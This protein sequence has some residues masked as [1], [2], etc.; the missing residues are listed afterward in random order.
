[1]PLLSWPDRRRTTENDGQ[2]M[3]ILVVEDDEKIAETLRKGLE[4]EGYR[5]R[6]AADGEEGFYRACTEPCDLIL[7]DLMLP[8]RDGLEVLRAVRRSGCRVPVLILTARDGVADRVAGLDDGADDYLVKPFSFAELLA[9]IRALLRRGSGTPAT[10][11]RLADLEVDRLRREARRGGSLLHLTGREFGLL[12]YL[13]RHAGQVV[14]REMLARDVWR[15][16]GRATPL[17][18]IIDVYIS[19][20]RKKVD[21][22]HPVRLIHTI[23]GVGFMAREE[24]G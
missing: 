1:M 23:R 6:L 13:L 5:V 20:L 2:A 15:E 21:Q 10:T 11:V 12:E 8:G 4:G 24:E 16:A 22:D 3:T 19:R 14:S 7:L 18:N 9:R 17:D